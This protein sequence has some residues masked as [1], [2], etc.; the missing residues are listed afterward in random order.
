MRRPTSTTLAVF[1]LTAYAADSAFAD[2][3]PPLAIA[4]FDAKQAREF[5]QQWAQ[6]TGK[7]LVY[8]NSIGMKMV[9][10][11]PGEF[12]MGIKDAAALNKLR[13][14]MLSSDG[15]WDRVLG[16]GIGAVINLPGHRVRLNRPIYMGAHEVT[17]GQFRIFTEQ[18]GYKTDAECG[19]VYEKTYEGEEPIRT[20]Q[21]TFYEQA[22]DHPVLQVGW[23]DC[24]AFCK[25]LSKQEAKQGHEY[26]LPADAQ[27]EYA[28][29][30]GTTT[31]WHFGDPDEYKQVAHQYA[32]MSWKSGTRPIAVG[33]KKPNAFGLFDMHGNLCEWVADWHHW[34]YYLESPLNDPT[35]PATQNEH[36]I[37]RRWVRGGA[38]NVSRYWARSDMRIRIHQGSNQHDHVGFRVAMHAKD[39]K[40]AEPAEE[41]NM[42]IV[43]EDKAPADAVAAQETAVTKDRPKELKI[44]LNEDVSMEFVLVPAGSFLMGSL[45]GG[46]YERPVHQVVISKPFYI[47][48]YEVTQGQ[49]DAVMGNG[50]HK[51]RWGEKVASSLRR[52]WVGPNKP[53]FRVSWNDW[54]DFI[55]G[56]QRKAPKRDFSLPTEAQWE[57]ACRAGSKTEYCFGDDPALLGEHAWITPDDAP[58][59]R[60]RIWPDMAVGGRKPNKWG[61]HDMHGNAWEWCQDWWDKDYYSKSPLKDP[62]GPVDGNFKV[63]RGGAVK[64]YGRFARSAFRLF[65]TADVP[66]DDRTLLTGARLVINLPSV[67]TAGRR[68]HHLEF[69]VA[70]SID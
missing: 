58:H 33:Q 9:L 22:D 49:W 29:R 24:M 65:I 18:S 3:H 41:P 30:A 20:W 38:F 27:W 35:G 26:S 4:P 60:E 36:K 63:L 19:L 56:V 34:Y 46:R 28:C 14:N 7:E 50:N 57:Y 55:K 54:Q 52:E 67:E 10:L 62:Q 70:Q 37:T 8:T 48:K 5:Q 53:M 61:I 23:K 42:R 39:I 11:P 59:P 64:S 31:M 66:D 1:L 43:G 2:D 47:G 68:Y 15:H 6:Y 40:G 16:K 69:Q 13:E 51:T 17:V 12:M 25:W 45:K 32:N 21:K 44:K